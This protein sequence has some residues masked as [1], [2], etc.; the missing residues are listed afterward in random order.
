[1]KE[2]EGRKKEYHNRVQVGQEKL[3]KREK[4]LSWVDGDGVK[5]KRSREV[6]EN[7]LNG[8]CNSMM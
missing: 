2:E 8:I 7:V 3:R 4:Y 6:E 5:E 1:M